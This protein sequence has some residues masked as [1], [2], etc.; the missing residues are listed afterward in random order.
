MRWWGSGWHPTKRPAVWVA[1]GA[2]IILSSLFVAWWKADRLPQIFPPQLESLDRQV[3]S[4]GAEVFSLERYRSLH[5][6]IADLRTQWRKEQSRWWP[7]AD[8]HA[9]QAIYQQ[10]LHEGSTLL[11]ASKHQ[12]STRHQQLTAAL[13]SERRQ[14]TRLRALTGLFDVRRNVRALSVTEGLLNQADSRLMQDQ[15]G[16]AHV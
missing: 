10:L 6:D 14:V 4:H 13:E 12:Q 8:T 3:W 5:Q 11:E 2:L 15:I 1:A 7:T 9:L 16:R